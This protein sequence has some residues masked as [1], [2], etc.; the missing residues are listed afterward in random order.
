MK[1]KFEKISYESFKKTFPNISDEIVRRIYN[2]IKI[3]VR[4][5]KFSAG[6]DFSTPI[7]FVLEPNDSYI[8]PTGIKAYMN[9]DEYL[10]MYIRSSFGIKKDIIL[11]NGVGIIDSDYVDNESNE[12]H[13][14]V[15]IR[16][17]GDTTL[18]VKAGECVSQGIFQ[19]YYTTIDDESNEV[20]TGGIGS[21]TSV[22]KLEKAL[23]EDASQLLEIQKESFKGY[24]KKY[25]KFSSNPA[26]MSLD[27]M[28]FNINYRLGDYQKIIL[29]DKII[30]GIF[31]FILENESTWHIA[32]FYIH[33]DYEHL[34]YGTQAFQMYLD[35]HKFVKVWY[36]DTIKQE[37][38]N[39]EFYQKF[40]FKI[41][42]EEEENEGLSFVTLIK[43]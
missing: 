39:V 6:Y 27:R 4:K 25:G 29:K 21:T 31:S 32:Q 30:G 5:T 43:K 36:A 12:G 24:N 15:A 40:G 23:I 9:E 38:K 34:G 7:D 35:N 10:G 17:I 2:E 37:V 13:I 3:P 42:D 28:K 20:R 1:R 18:V 8:I 41:I 16:N 22:L 14:M 26:S 33:P 11:K 19:K